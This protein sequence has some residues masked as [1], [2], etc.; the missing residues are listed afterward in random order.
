MGERED[1]SH[2]MLPRAESRPR[3]TMQRSTRKRHV[4]A[5]CA[6]VLGVHAVV[7]KGVVVDV[8]NTIIMSDMPIIPGISIVLE[9]VDSDDEGIVM[10]PMSILAEVLLLS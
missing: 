4:R 9:E 8:K 5:Y 2:G 6:G 1:S 10:L 7:Y 3:K